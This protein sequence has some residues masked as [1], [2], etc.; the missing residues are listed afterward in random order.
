MPHGTCQ[1]YEIGG[2]GELRRLKVPFT[3]VPPF[4]VVATAAQIDTFDRLPHELAHLLA[5]VGR[6]TGLRYCRIVYLYDSDS[7]Q[8]TVDSAMVS[9]RNVGGQDL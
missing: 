2:F 3:N 9:F 8:D 6:D 4:F 1:L 7:Q 5:S